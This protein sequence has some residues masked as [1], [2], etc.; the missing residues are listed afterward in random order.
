MELGDYLK[1]PVYAALFAALV[2][3]GYIHVKAKINNESE[4]KPSEYMKPGALVGILVLFIIT[5][6][7]GGREMI[8]KEPF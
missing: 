6:G 7:I 4:L 2:T 8:S 5:Y 3:A 1:D